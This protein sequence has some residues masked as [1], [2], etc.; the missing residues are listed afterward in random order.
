MITLVTRSQ[1]GL[2]K[3]GL[4][5]RGR[6][7][8]QLDLHHHTFRRIVCIVFLYVILQ[9]C[10]TPSGFIYQ[11]LEDKTC[12]NNSTN[13]GFSLSNCYLYEIQGKLSEGQG[14]VGL[15]VWLG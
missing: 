6:G 5:S 9:L 15:V 12:S 14:L 1:F 10:C 2:K 7:G 3:T 4:N 8:W 13:I 11:Q